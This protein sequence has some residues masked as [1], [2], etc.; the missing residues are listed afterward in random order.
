MASLMT[1]KTKVRKNQSNKRNLNK[2]IAKIMRNRR[3]MRR[4]VYDVE[5]SKGDIE[6]I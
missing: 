5:D 3:R 1:H 2:E 4:E 6:H